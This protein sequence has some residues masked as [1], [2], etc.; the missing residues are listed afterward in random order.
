MIN[1]SALSRG[2]ARFGIYFKASAFSSASMH[3]STNG[4]KPTD[5]NPNHV[6][7]IA[8]IMQY[9]VEKIHATITLK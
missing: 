6:N 7:F 4:L 1:T 2:S 5:S 3:A 8:V 9:P